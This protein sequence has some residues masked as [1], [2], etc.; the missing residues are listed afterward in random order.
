MSKF[1]QVGKN[2]VL[3]AEN[4]NS[5]YRFNDNKVFIQF[6]GQQE[7]ERYEGAE[8]KAIWAYFTAATPNICPAAVEK[9]N[10]E[11][12]TAEGFSENIE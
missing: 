1:I 4:V 11:T 5:V 3:N 7:P 10:A 8:A 6:T 9:K 2:F 12:L